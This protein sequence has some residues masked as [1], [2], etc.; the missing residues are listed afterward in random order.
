MQILTL[1]LDEAWREVGRAITGKR[2]SA[3]WEHFRL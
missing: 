1:L 3:R 2:G